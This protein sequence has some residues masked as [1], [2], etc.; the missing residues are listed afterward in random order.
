MGNF[1]TIPRLKLWK[2]Y[3]W[4]KAL[5]HQVTYPSNAVHINTDRQALLL[6]ETEEINNWARL[7]AQ[8]YF[9]WFAVVLIF[10]GLGAGWLFTHN[11]TLPRF[12]R[13][14]FLIFIG[15]DAMGAAVTY[16]IRKHMLDCDLRISEL[17]WTLTQ[18]QVVEGPQLRP[19]SPVP[20]R[21]I[22]TVFVFTGATLFMFLLFWVTLF[23]L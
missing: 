5:E 2:L 13:L 18:H 4:D 15:F 22:N 8:L 1:K 23:L 6:K 9:G 12:A 10:N 14:I 16:F 7:G 19:R 21:A 17:I 3:V 20:R 11:D